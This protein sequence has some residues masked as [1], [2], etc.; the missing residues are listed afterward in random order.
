MKSQCLIVV[1]LL[2]LNKGFAAND[3]II[4]KILGNV[5]SKKM[6]SGGN[7]AGSSPTS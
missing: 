1:V 7:T 3:C 4:G 2:D 5:I 6:D